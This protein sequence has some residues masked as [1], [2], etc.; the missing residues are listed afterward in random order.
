MR[1]TF[2]LVLTKPF[3]KN[4][5]FHKDHPCFPN[6]DCRKVGMPLDSALNLCKKRRPIV[7]PIAPFISQLQQ[8]EAKCRDLG[9]IQTSGDKGQSSTDG[10][11]HCKGLKRKAIGPS[12]PPLDTKEVESMV[13]RPS[14]II[15]HSR[16]GPA[17]NS[18]N[19]E[20][21]TNVEDGSQKIAADT[22]DAPSKRLK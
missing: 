14:E 21:E 16:Q 6:G 13:M 4:F 15:T 17:E 20:N 22:K 1:Y 10:D 19:H 2:N 7:D 11:I 3:N 9:L 8:Y 5:V 18:N 12:R